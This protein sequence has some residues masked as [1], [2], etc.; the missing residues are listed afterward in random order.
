MTYAEFLSSALYFYLSGKP[1]QRFFLF[2]IALTLLS[3]ILGLATTSNRISLAT[4]I[5]YFV[6]LI[7]M[8]FIAIIFICLICLYIYKSK[9][10]LFENITYDFTHWGVT[11][12]GERTK[13]SKPWREITKFKETKAFFLLCIGNTDFHIIQK[14][15]FETSGE[16]NDFRNLLKENINS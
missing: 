11:R 9:S 4:I 6:P 16:L 10:Y 1:L 3:M 5:N 13:F 14:R 7:I 12:H 2:L 8:F 15:M